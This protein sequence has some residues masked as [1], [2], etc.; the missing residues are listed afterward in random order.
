MSD[1]LTAARERVV[2]YD[3]AMGTGI[4]AAGLTADDF[5]G[6]DLE[7]CN[8]LLVVTRP[9][10]I[11]GLHAAY[12]EVGCDVV[13]TDS[14]GS[15]GLTLAEY[16]IAERAH[17][18]N[19]AAARV[20]KEVASSFATP[21][22]PRWVAGSIGPGTKFPSLGQIRYAEMRDEY[23]DQAHG[24]LEGGVDL[25]IIETFFDLLSVKAA[26]NGAR[27]AMR[28]IGREVPLQVQVTMELTGRMLPG[29]EIG[30]ALA[31]IDPAEARRHRHQLRHR[32][33]GDGRAPPPS[34]RPRPHPDLVHPQRRACRASST[35]RCTTTSRPP[36]WPST[37]PGSSPSSA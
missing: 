16:G 25:L 19:V 12:L 36:S 6:P 37:T 10:F 2:I 9:E 18:L 11:K 5:G 27:R 30:A 15:L 14:F 35:A 22:R 32:P 33:G 8:E 26:M 20:A 34:R 24:L 23:E 3:G 29:T 4:Q 1:F 13:E 7:G 31:A 17:E 28:A 21:D